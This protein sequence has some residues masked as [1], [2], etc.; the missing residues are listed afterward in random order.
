MSTCSLLID[1]LKSLWQVGLRTYDVAKKN[2][3]DMRAALMWKK[4]IFQLTGCSLDGVRTGDYR[5]LSAWTALR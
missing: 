5:V 2:F 1:E 3:F 4:T